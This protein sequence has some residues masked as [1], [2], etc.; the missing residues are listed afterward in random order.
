MKSVYFQ[1][2]MQELLMFLQKI[3][4]RADFF[5]TT[6]SFV[7]GFIKCMK[8]TAKGHNDPILLYLKGSLKILS[9]VFGFEVLE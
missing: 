4:C 1:M 2:Q 8:L 7:D 5:L 6:L 9:Q 3:N